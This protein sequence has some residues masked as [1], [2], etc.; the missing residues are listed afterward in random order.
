MTLY[1]SS[2]KLDL[3][4]RSL[5]ARSKELPPSSPKG[6]VLKKELESFRSACPSPTL[7]TA[8]SPGSQILQAPITP[9]VTTSLSKPAAVTGKLEVR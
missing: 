9:I 6:E 4:R 7:Y 5:Q 8:L 2:Q 3:I 1:E